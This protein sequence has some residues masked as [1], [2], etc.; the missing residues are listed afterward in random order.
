MAGSLRANPRTLKSAA[1]NSVL[2]TKEP[3]PLNPPL[4]SN[5]EG[6]RGMNRAVHA[7]GGEVEDDD[8]PRNS[9]N[10]DTHF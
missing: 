1:T 8:Q 2:E 4:R 3:H 7:K 10:S 6:D 9:R 5:G